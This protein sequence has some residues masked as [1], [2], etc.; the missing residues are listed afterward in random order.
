MEAKEKKKQDD[1]IAK[2]NRKKE[3]EQKK[4]LREAEAKRKAEERERKIVERQR[5]AAE[6]AAERERKAAERKREAQERELKKR[7]KAETRRTCKRVSNKENKVPVDDFQG[8]QRAEINQN[9]CAVCLGVYD[10]DLTDGVLQKEWIRCTNTDTCGLWMH[11]E[12]LNK[13]PS[14]NYVCLMCN[15]TFA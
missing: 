13:D 10:D 4:L 2:E 3:R 6:R 9:E 12:C 15:T 7:A 14:D 5:K 8:L 1:V 11:C